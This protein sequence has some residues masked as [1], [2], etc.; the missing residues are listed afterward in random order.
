M[1]VVK[2]AVL[3][4]AGVGG[5]IGFP[6][7]NIFYDGEEE[8]VFAAEVEIEGFKYKAAVNLGH[9]PTVDDKCFC[10]AHLLDF[11]KENFAVGKEMSVELLKR[12]RDIK[13]FE[14]LGDLQQQIDED[15]KHV[16]EFF[17]I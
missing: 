8:G 4:G 7:L 6:T 9:R 13:K 12:I 14:N 16:R 2:G 5:E 10:E 15:L 3:K 17:G 1:K 11:D